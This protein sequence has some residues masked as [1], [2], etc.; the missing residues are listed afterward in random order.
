MLE[1]LFAEKSGGKKSLRKE[2]DSKMLAEIEEF[3]KISFNWNYL[4]NFSGWLDEG[5]VGRG[6]EKLR[7]MLK[8]LREIWDSVLKTPQHE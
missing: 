8:T 2:I 6:L 4:L 5:N 3:H 1:S 7:K